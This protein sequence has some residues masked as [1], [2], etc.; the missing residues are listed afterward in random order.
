MSLFVSCFPSTPKLGAWGRFRCG[1]SFKLANQSR[2]VDKMSTCGRT[3]KRV[4]CPLRLI[5]AG[6][7]SIFF[8]SAPPILVPTDTFSAQVWRVC[9]FSHQLVVI[10]TGP[11]VEKSVG[12]SSVNWLA[13]LYFIH[14][15]SASAYPP[16]DRNLK[17]HRQSKLLISIKEMQVEKRGG[18]TKGM[19]RKEQ[20]GLKME[21]G[22]LPGLEKIW[23][24][25]EFLS[26]EIRDQI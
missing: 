21:S 2:L 23:S 7:V 8:P 17:S 24:R 4:V 22:L 14:S 1:C 10:V 16:T 6:R 15:L 13:H 18:E 26:H 11:S 19:G 25:F 5:K 12:H 20:T 9:I 3:G